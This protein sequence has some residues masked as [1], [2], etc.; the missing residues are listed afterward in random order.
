MI[1]EGVMEENKGWSRG[2]TILTELDSNLE[3]LQELLRTEAWLTADQARTIKVLE[4]RVDRLESDLVG[5]ITAAFYDGSEEQCAEAAQ[6]SAELH[7]HEGTTEFENI[8][9]LLMGEQWTKQEEITKRV[10]RIRLLRSI[11]EVFGAKD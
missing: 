11:I 10:E 6:K 9:K 5:A 8:I 4:Q 2:M 7:A 1:V 3:S